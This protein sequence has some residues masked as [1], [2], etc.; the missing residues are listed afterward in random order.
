MEP[1]LN[2]SALSWSTEINFDELVSDSH[3]ISHCINRVYVSSTV[4]G[5][6]KCFEKIM[7]ES[8]RF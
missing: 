4:D 3:L 5:S 1:F 6:S 7:C 8:D 2:D